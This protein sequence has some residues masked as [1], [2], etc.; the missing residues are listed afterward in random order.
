MEQLPAR[1][2]TLPEEPRS[3]QP[4]PKTVPE[5]AGYQSVGENQRQPEITEPRITRTSN[6]WII[7]LWIY[8]VLVLVVIIALWLLSVRNKDGNPL[9]SVAPYPP[10]GATAAAGGINPPPVPVPINYPN[11]YPYYLLRS[12]GNSI[13]VILLAVL[14]LAVTYRQEQLITI[15]MILLALVYACLVVMEISFS[16]NGFGRIAMM[17]VIA[18]LL[19]LVLWLMVNRNS[20]IGWSAYIALL[21]ANLWFLYLAYEMVKLWQLN[22]SSQ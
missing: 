22:G 5:S 12:I 11:G 4:W 14:A 3:P 10:V 15:F 9:F 21:F 7:S 13:I 17:G 18:F 20:V 16:I 1:V 6:D 8:I 19:S 2:L